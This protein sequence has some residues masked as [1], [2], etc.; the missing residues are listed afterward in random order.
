MILRLGYTGGKFGRLAMSEKRQER[1]EKLQEQKK[2]I[3]N[4][5]Q[6]EKNKESREQKKK[7]DRRKILVGAYC[8]DLLSK[9]ESVPEIKTRKELQK[10]MDQFLVRDG[11][12]ALF[13]LKPKPQSDQSKTT[14]KSS[15]TVTGNQ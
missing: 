8:L 10:R 12:R 14:K 5:I 9:G 13:G 3:Q 11:D 7:E 1:I 6:Q 2:Q 4:R 15:S